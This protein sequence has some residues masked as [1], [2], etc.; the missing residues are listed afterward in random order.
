MLRNNYDYYYRRETGPHTSPM[1]EL[2]PPHPPEGL[3]RDHPAF[4]GWSSMKF[5]LDFPTASKAA[6]EAGNLYAGTI[7]SPPLAG[8]GQRRCPA[9]L[10]AQTC[11]SRRGHSRGLV[12]GCGVELNRQQKGKSQKLITLVT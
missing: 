5:T 4:L 3:H 11:L 2:L 10:W 7:T 6:Y 1:S 8:W 12:S 9:H